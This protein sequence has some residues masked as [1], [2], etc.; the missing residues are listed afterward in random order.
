[1]SGFTRTVQARAERMER[2]H[3]TRRER[4]VAAAKAE[5][6]VSG[7]NGATMRGIA[8]AAGVTTGAV[9][10]YFASKEELY[11]AVLEGSL[12]ELSAHIRARIAEAASGRA[13]AEALRGFFDFYR[14]RTD[15]LA[16][17]LYLYNGIGPSG[18]APGL[19]RALNARLRDVFGD[20]EQAFLADG[21]DDAPVRTANGIAQ[22]IGLL[23]MERTRRLK[24]L[25]RSAAELFDRYLE[26]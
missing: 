22:A 21:R 5:F 9:Y 15:E 11:A 24:L 4:I 6:A 17:G 20:I 10:P 26:P 13:G 12:T 3:A 14:E 23:V 2:K 25:G 8:K 7:L 1:M 18:L 19:D 16:L